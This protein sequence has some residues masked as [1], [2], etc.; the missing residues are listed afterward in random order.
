[1][2]DRLSQFVPF[3]LGKHH[4]PDYYRP[5][6]P[7]FLRGE[8]TDPWDAAYAFGVDSVM[9]TMAIAY[10][11]RAGRKPGEPVAKDITKA[12]ECLQRELGRV[13][14]DAEELRVDVEELDAMSGALTKFR[15]RS[16]ADEQVYPLPPHGR[17]CS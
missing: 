17:D 15:R 16:A 1:V 12:M 7:A 3:E 9:L 4:H 11:L 2:E 13:A 10:L 8:D 5:K 14:A 6:R